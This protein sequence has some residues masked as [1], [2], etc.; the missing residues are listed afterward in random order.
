MCVLLYDTLCIRSHKI[1]KAIDCLTR[2]WCDDCVIHNL[3]V[4]ILV[5]NVYLVEM[6]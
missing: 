6:L 5:V 4:C 1:R 3:D 2:D